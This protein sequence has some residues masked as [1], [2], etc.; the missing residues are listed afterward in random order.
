MKIYEIHLKKYINMM[1]KVVNNPR[2]NMHKFLDLGPNMHELSNSR[3]IFIELLD[4]G[5]LDL[6]SIGVAEN[7]L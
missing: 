1:Y 3:S 7:P 5:L 2:P 4:L 6:G